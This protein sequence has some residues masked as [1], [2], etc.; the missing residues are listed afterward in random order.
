M[1]SRGTHESHVQDL[2]GPLCAHI[3]TTYGLTNESILNSSRYF[4]VVEGMVPDIMH[5]ILEGT[6]Q[7]TLKCLLRHLTENQNF[8][9]FQKLNSRINSFNYGPMDLPNRP[10]EISKDTLKKYDSLQQSGTKKL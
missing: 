5:D 9:S 10:S 7:V 8:L 1:R 3:S 6:A 2:N 4:H